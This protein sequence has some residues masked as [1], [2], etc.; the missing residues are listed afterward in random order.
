MVLLSLLLCPLIFSGT[1]MG[2]SWPL[3]SHLRLDPA[4]KLTAT[5]ALSLL[6]IFLVSWIIYVTAMPLVWMNVL[7]LAGALGLLTG[8]RPLCVMLRDPDARVLA[9]GQ[10][11]VML[12]SCAGLA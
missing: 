8:Y 3:S 1:V 7:P 12:W 6:A 5:I 9:T 2:L 4:E 11:L 10:L